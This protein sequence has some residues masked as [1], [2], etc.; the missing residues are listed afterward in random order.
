MIRWLVAGGRDRSQRG[1][2]ERHFGT[3]GLQAAMAGLNEMGARQQP[4][5]PIYA[6]R[7]F[8]L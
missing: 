4:P 8:L 2:L 6:R 7:E 1:E 5:I 3:G